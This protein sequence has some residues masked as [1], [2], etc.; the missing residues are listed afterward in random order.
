MRFL[1]E[2]TWTISSEAEIADFAA[3]P[4]VRLQQE[5]DGRQI[6]IV[7]EDGALV[8][9]SLPLMLPDIDNVQFCVSGLILAFTAMVPFNMMPPISH[10]LNVIV[11]LTLVSVS[12]PLITMEPSTR[13]GSSIISPKGKFGEVEP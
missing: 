9:L 7:R 6:E 1:G 12:V 2:R 8:T 4:A 13:H 11:P 10:S 3:D 5:G